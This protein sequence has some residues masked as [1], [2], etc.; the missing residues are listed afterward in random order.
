MAF[1]S[2]VRQE[3]RTG[4]VFLFKK[5]ALRFAKKNSGTSGCATMFLA[6]R[7]E[8]DV[9]NRG[10]R[11]IAWI[12]ALLNLVTRYVP[13]YPPPIPLLERQRKP[14]WLWP[15]KQAGTRQAEFMNWRTAA[16]DRTGSLRLAAGCGRGPGNV[17]TKVQRLATQRATKRSSFGSLRL[18]HIC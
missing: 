12:G 1:G 7:L 6:E 3:G 9:E 5:S 4:G 14:E 17:S 2:R 16:Q 15:A 13:D 18:R 10:N 8:L 11:L